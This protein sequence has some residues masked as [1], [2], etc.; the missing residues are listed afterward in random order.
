VAHRL[1]P[2]APDPRRHEADAL[3]PELGTDV[4]DKELAPP[5]IGS[6]KTKP[7]PWLTKVI[8]G[9]E[10]AAI[11]VAKASALS[12]PSHTASLSSSTSRFGLFA[13]E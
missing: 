10:I 6:E 2:S 12:A 8:S 13:R 4:V 1:K 9:M 5:Q 7:S 3:H 11:P